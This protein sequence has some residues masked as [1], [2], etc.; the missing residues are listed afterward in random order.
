MISFRQFFENRTRPFLTQ[1]EMLRRG[2]DGYLTKAREMDI[3][4]AKIDG[5]EPVPAMEDGYK[6]GTPITQPIEVEYNPTNDTYILYSGNHR[7]RQ[8]EIN[9]QTT[10]KAFVQFPAK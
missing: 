4:L 1:Q 7:V 6:P 5:R 10:I 2:A 9:G 8:A 3:P